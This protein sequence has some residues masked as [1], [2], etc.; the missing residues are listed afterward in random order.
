[1]ASDKKADLIGNRYGHL[2]WRRR[3]IKYSTAST[4]TYNISRKK[5]GAIFVVPTVSTVHLALPKISSLALGLN[6]EFYFSSAADKEDYTIASTIDSSAH[7][8]M[9]GVTSAASTAS[10]VTPLSTVD[11]NACKLTAISSVAW[12]FEN[13]Y[14]GGW[15]SANTS[16]LTTADNELGQWGVGT[17]QA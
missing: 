8:L 14:G 15:S 1:M 11:G 3:V 4:A 16:D 7:I 2:P 17:T 6:Y 10:A 12:L 5:S 9:N 13:A